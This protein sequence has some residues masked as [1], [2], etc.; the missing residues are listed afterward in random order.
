MEMTYEYVLMVNGVPM[1]YRTMS[2]R[3]ARKLN[4]EYEID[5]LDFKWIRGEDD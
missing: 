5:F 4:K 2:P 1:E 3:R